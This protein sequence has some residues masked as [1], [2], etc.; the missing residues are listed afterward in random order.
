MRG[1]A[2]RQA[3]RAF[4]RSLIPLPVR[5]GKS[6]PNNAVSSADFHLGNL[7][8]EKGPHGGPHNNSKG[9]GNEP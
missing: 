2:M 9:L 4:S 1:G 5:C 3:H 7:L 6:N 8:A